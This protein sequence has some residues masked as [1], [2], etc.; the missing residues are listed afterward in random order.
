M[1][2]LFKNI[3][4]L[5]DD[6]EAFLKA[7]HLVPFFYYFVLLL[8]ILKVEGLRP[9]L[10]QG[11]ES[12]SPQWPIFWAAFVDYT[13]AGN[14][15]ILLFFFTALY[16]CFSPWNTYARLLSFIGLVQFHAFASS[17][18]STQQQFVL[19]VWVAFF[20]I[21][22]PSIKTLSRVTIQDRK[23]TLLVFFFAQAYFFL[24]YTMAG[25]GKVYGGIVQSLNGE[26]SIFSFDAASLH[27]TTWLNIMDYGE[28]IGG[29]F[30]IEHQMI[31][32]ISLLLVVYLQLFSFLVVFRPS[33]HRVWALAL[34]F[35][36]IG[37]YITMRAF[38]PLH[39]SLLVILFFNSPFQTHVRLRDMLKDIPVISFFA[40]SV[41][42]LIKR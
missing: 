1:S 40:K 38:F 25:I 24:T 30:L 36:H 17:F 8:A 35:F 32:W 21:F 19:Y 5:F 33:L 41:T 37:T 6:K 10:Q 13:T 27:I 34:V 29:R 16:A 12:F 15:V 39:I 42:F 23:K 18:G 22:L 2:K 4:R 26:A 31:G 11:V 9:L 28:T 7:Y 20:F 14:I 3:E